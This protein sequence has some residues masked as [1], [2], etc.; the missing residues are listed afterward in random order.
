MIDYESSDVFRFDLGPIL[1]DQTRIAKLK[2]A[3]NLL[4]LGPRIFKFF[5]PSWIL[6]EM[7]NVIYLEN[8]NT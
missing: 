2:N 6:V 5:P 7:E 8:C 4:I 3:Y 1:Q